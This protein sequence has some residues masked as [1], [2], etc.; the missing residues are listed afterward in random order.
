MVKMHLN[1]EQ[2]Y[3]FITEVYQKWPQIEHDTKCTLISSLWN[4]YH[5][6]KWKLRQNVQRLIK[7][8]PYEL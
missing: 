5:K 6:V 8:S 4:I 7:S 1:Q 3:K 2:K